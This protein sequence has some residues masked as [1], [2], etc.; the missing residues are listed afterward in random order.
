MICKLEK[1]KINNLILLKNKKV[2][3][4]GFIYKD[5]LNPRLEMTWGEFCW[6]A[7]RACIY[8]YF[9]D[10]WIKIWN[11]KVS[12]T[13]QILKTYIDKKWGKYIY[14]TQIPIYTDTKSIKK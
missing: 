3:Q 1:E 7:T 5:I 11:I 10:F 13:N 6:N 2:E 8:K 9:K 12:W 14:Q 4:V